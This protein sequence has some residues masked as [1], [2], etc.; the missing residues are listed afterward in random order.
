M[1]LSEHFTLDEMIRSSSIYDNTPG[2]VQIERLKYLC[3]N[4]E[5][6]RELVGKPIRI[7]SGFRSEMVNHAVGGSKTSDHK[8]GAAADFEV[9]G[10]SNY[11]LAKLIA[12]SDLEWKQL[13]LEFYT[14]GVENSGWV[15]CSFLEGNKK[16][17]VLTAA[18]VKGKTVYTAGLHK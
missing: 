10:M 6:I 1:K 17:E 9:E 16:K 5:K 8:L 7:N 12:E 15:H 3:E 18:R 14:P 13:I 11:E 2:D 4:L